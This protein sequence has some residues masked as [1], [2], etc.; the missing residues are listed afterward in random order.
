MRLQIK[1]AFVASLNRG[2]HQNIQRDPSSIQSRTFSRLTQLSGKTQEQ[3]WFADG[4]EAARRLKLELGIIPPESDASAIGTADNGIVDA[5]K[6]M[7]DSMLESG[8]AAA[9]ALLLGLDGESEEGKR[10]D[11]EADES[12]SEDVTATDHFKLPSKKSHCMTICM[13]PPPSAKV[14]WKQLS[15]ARRECR[16]PGFHRWPPHANMLYPFLE[17]IYDSGGESG[18]LISGETMDEKREAF[19]CDVVGFI[20]KATQRCAPFEVTIDT[21]GTFGGKH[22]GVLWA[23]PRS[24]TTFLDGSN[25][26]EP[27]IRL[28]TLLEEKFPMC[29]DTRKAGGKFNPHITLSHYVNVTDA[30]AAK[31]EVEAK[32]TPV[33]F[34]LQEIYLLERRGDEGQFKILATIPLGS[35]NDAVIHNPPVPFP[36]MP[37]AEEDWVHEERMKLKNRRRNGMKRRRRKGRSK[38]DSA[39]E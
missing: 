11:D 35:E 39:E 29:N 32:W 18:G 24:S 15:D 26:E 38:E 13:V 20:S 33:S 36:D 23:Y 31:H 37:R 25:D 17:P 30:L 14:A 12:P 10:Q 7:H 27:L 1:A 16:D 19:I 3:D 28:Q 34:N 21:F 9:R 5:S 22:R 8:R 6:T 4:R 2:R